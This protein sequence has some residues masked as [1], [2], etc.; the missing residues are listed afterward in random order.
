M[1]P[2][3]LLHKRLDSLAEKLD[4][5][6]KEVLLLNKL[7]VI[8][9]LSSEA[10]I[11]ALSVAIE[12]IE[13]N[14]AVY[15]NEKNSDKSP[16]AIVKKLN[17]LAK[18][19]D[20]REACL[21]LYEGIVKSNEKAAAKKEQALK[22]M[23]EERRATLKNQRMQKELNIIY[24]ITLESLHYD[25]LNKYLSYIHNLCDDQLKN[26]FICSAEG[27]IQQKAK[28]YQEALRNKI[29]VFNQFAH[30]ILDAIA[31]LTIARYHLNL[32]EAVD[33]K[34]KIWLPLRPEEISINNQDHFEKLKSW[35]LSIQ[36]KIL[37]LL[38]TPPLIVEEPKPNKLE[39]LKQL[40]RKSFSHPKAIAFWKKQV[41][42]GDH[43]PTGIKEL[44]KQ[45]SK[46]QDL[47]SLQE[48][49]EKILGR[50]SIFCCGKP[51]SRSPITHSYYLLINGL[52]FDT[53]VN[54]E[55]STRTLTA[56][57]QK[58]KIDIFAEEKPCVTF[59]SSSRTKRM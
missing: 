36:T 32:I 59:P 49:C 35:A 3:E 15:L 38:T 51:L 14:V 43:V 44:S 25:Y 56:W 2:R 58:Y 7:E 5:S 57:L 54:I 52:Q 9:N 45:F 27:S 12:A 31:E 19:I 11:A 30:Y 46:D 37:P 1:N 33:E 8:K 24:E 29:F 26:A 18:I 23:L 20:A 48:Q 34:I 28:I 40:I 22:L 21:A 16:T 47:D 4:K 6:E 10:D 17:Q 50:T 13:Q 42:I 53:A 55:K 39:L 41:W